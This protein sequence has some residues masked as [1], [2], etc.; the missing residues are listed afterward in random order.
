MFY[1]AKV[2]PMT[3]EEIEEEEQEEIFEKGSNSWRDS[4]FLGQESGD[5]NAQRAFKILFPPA[6]WLSSLIFAHL[7][8]RAAS[9]A[10]QWFTYTFLYLVPPMGKEVIIP[11]GINA[12][13]P[14]LLMA[15]TI[16]FVDLWVAMFIAW[17]Y[18]Y[19]EKIPKVGNI[20]KKTE[21][22]GADLIA[23]SPAAGKGAWWSIVI[24]A[25]IPFIGAGGFLG[26]IIG[27]FIGMK[28]VDII[29]AV[30]AG[31][32]LS[33]LMYAYAADA[34]FT[35]FEKYPWL[36]LVVIVIV[37]LGIY[38]SYRFFKRESAKVKK[39]E[40]SDGADSA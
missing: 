11:M 1:I 22:K 31:A 25:L 34:I 17:N 36:T 28:P 15:F 5:S 27:R 21:K 30:F 35:S 7:I 18:W 3:E 20:L 13:Y 24:L 9:D 6:F 29:T 19:L 23:K 10:D 37:F 38:G 12:G 2:A 39:A 8:F 40:A 14:P 32:L 4:L 33:G 16:T 26:S